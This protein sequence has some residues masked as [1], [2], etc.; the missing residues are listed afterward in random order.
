MKINQRKLAL[1]NAV[2][3]LIEE[4]KD[5]EKIKMVEIAEKAAMGKGTIYEYFPSKEKLFLETIKYFANQDLSRLQ[6]SLCLEDGFK[7]GYF[8]LI[9]CLSQQMNRNLVFFKNLIINNSFYF[10]EQQQQQDLDDFIQEVQRSYHELFQKLIA[11]GIKE[12]K[13]KKP[14][15]F[16]LTLAIYNTFMCLFLSKAGV[17]TFAEMTIEEVKAE[18]YQLM[19]KILQ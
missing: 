6:A 1:Y 13:I 10:L 3:A 9:H 2:F 8:K 12:K 4:K 17:E 5:L 19:I 11:Q 16:E 18:T 14:S 7:N 15:K